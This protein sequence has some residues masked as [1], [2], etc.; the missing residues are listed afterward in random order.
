MITV[1]AE[2]ETVPALLREVVGGFGSNEFIVADE[3]RA[4]YA[5]IDERSRLLA[6][7]LLRA[8]VGKGTRVALLFPSGTAFVVT[9]TA[10][11]RIGAVAVPLSTLATAPEL[12]EAIRFADVQHIVAIS[13]HL[14]HDYAQKLV[15]AF[16][17]LSGSTPAIEIDDA[18][19]L[20]SIWFASP[21]APAWATSLDDLPSA[22]ETVVRA[23]EDAVVASDP[24][25][26]VFS[27]GSTGTPKAVVHSHGTLTRQSAKLQQDW[28]YRPDD[29]IYAALPFFWV[30][31][32]SFVLL[33]TMRSGATVVV[34]S[35][36]SPIAVLDLLER[37]RVTI[38]HMWPHTARTIAADPTFADRSLVVRAGS[39]YEA[40]LG[41]GDPTLL[42][43]ALG[44]TE[45]AG[46]H[47]AGQARLVAEHLRGAFGRPMPGLEHRIV[48]PD[49]GYDSDVGR[50]GELWLR[51]DTV[52]VGLYRREAHTVFVRDGWYRTG[53]L[54]SLRDGHLFFRGRVDDQMKVSGVNVSPNEIER[55]LL[56]VPG[57]AQAFVVG[58]ADAERGAVVAAAV[59]PDANGPLEPDEI[60][61]A[62]RG[63][64]A[65]YNV[66][67]I[68]GIFDADAIPLKLTGKLDRVRLAEILADLPRPHRAFEP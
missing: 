67:R 26:I 5:A 31:G 17:S 52:A 1:A 51:G 43:E 47:T 6:A 59:V 25:S 60:R 7:K 37:E 64:L 20:R 27:S 35:D 50:R 48:D 10:V 40:W 23:A 19:F 32:L 56:E 29:R 2:G 21:D 3:E 14:R 33:T 53:D 57:V 18:P 30:G 41:D 68:I 11:V 38:T 45:T 62:V 15:E 65:S 66:P 34:S 12:R 61:A 13:H 28:C 49:T 4:T 42:S 44:M 24:V 22:S 9:W 58:V 16:P 63:S 39:L 8:G 55:A 54:C 36:N 46:P